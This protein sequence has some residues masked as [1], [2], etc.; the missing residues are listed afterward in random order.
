MKVRVEGVRVE[1]ECEYR[2]NGSRG[3]REEK[4]C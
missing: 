1:K 2:R 4:E 3:V